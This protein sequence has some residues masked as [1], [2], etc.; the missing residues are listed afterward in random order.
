MA[1]TTAEEMAKQAGVNPRTFR[2][3]LRK[4][5]FAWH[6]HYDCWTVAIGNDEHAAMQRVLRKL[7]K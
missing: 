6:A 3:A 2:Q 5:R 1:M 4:E 7:S